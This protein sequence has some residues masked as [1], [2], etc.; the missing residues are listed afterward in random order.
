M[1]IHPGYMG[2]ASIGGNSF[3]FE[4]CSLT[5]KQA[6]ETPDMVMGNWDHA[7]YHAGKVDVSGSI[8]GPA[9]EGF[10]TN[11]DGIFAW[12]A[13]RNQT[14][15]Q[16]NSQPVTLIY[17]CDGNGQGSGTTGKSSRIFT[18]VYANNLTFSCT[19][20]DNAQFSVD[21]MSAIKPTWGDDQPS[22][23]PAIE[24]IIT[25]DTCSVTIN[26]GGLSIPTD[27]LLSAFEFSI[28]NN[29]TPYYSLPSLSENLGYYPT[30]IIPGLRTVTGSLT[31]Y[32]PEAFDGVDNYGDFTSSQ[33]PSITFTIAGRPFTVN[34][35][36]HR[37]EPTLT[38]GPIMSTI[39]FTGVG[40][41]DG[42]NS[43]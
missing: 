5:A 29:C 25:W 35:Q 31:A 23:N 30:A 36:F 11:I 24:K 2:A 18:S 40:T 7:A 43:F 8:S 32:D 37:V 14:C 12:A 38:V 9:T 3:R 4:S 34:C 39:A 21:M 6:W 22:V 19:A 1:A 33:I 13:H 10:I 17:Y 26:N 42:L 16:L 27:A 41:Q 28:N 15:G 20:G